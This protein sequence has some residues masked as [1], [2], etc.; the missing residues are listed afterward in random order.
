MVK[1]RGVAEVERQNKVPKTMN[2]P[3]T[4]RILLDSFSNQES[5]IVFEGDGGVPIEVEGACDE[6]SSWIR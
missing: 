6:R 5:H 2:H 3:G 1:S 4:E